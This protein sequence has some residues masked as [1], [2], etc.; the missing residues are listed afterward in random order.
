M[1]VAFSWPAFALCVSAYQ[2][3]LRSEPSND[4][5]I[6]WVV[7]RYMPLVEIQRKGSWIKV[8]DV[9]GEIHW[10]LAS[11]LSSR[12][13]CV[14]VKDR[15]A[16]LRVGPSAQE[17][18]AEIQSVDRYTAFKRIEAEPEN[19]YRIEDEAG[20]KYWILARQVWRAAT[21]THLGF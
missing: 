5:K 11:E 16:Q 14:V 17:P 21:V 15:V 9:D 4:A 18:L 20:N 3:R 12:Q 10:A 2:T 6:T 13:R 19:W 8:Q 7:G 1:V